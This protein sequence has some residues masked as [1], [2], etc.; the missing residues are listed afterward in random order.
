M[1]NGA[2]AI[3]AVYYMGEGGGLSRRVR[4]KLNAHFGSTIPLMELRLSDD[5]P[6]RLVD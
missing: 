6:F 3:E 1:R 4:D 2:A 5:A